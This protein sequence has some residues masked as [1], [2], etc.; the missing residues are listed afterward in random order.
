[1]CQHHDHDH[2][3]DRRGFLGLA[4]ASLAAAG[5]APT[6]SFAAG[7]PT[8]S[9]TADQARLVPILPPADATKAAG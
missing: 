9:L 5:I 3:L 1:M 2:K 7:G 4:M 8:T 6:T